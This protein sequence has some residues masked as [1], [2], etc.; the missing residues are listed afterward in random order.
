MVPALYSMGRK[1]ALL[2]SLP[3]S[4]DS[5]SAGPIGTI[6]IARRQLRFHVKQMEPSAPSGPF[7]TT[8]LPIPTKGG[9]L[10]GSASMSLL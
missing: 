3:K 1:G 7:S 9:A 5:R 8:Q 6:V 10:L 4:V 2:L